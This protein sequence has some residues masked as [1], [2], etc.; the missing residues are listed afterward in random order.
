MSV[1]S[2]L[3]EGLR[4][5]TWLRHDCG[6]VEDVLVLQGKNRPEVSSG[7]ALN[8]EGLLFRAGCL[9][10]VLS[11]TSLTVLSVLAVMGDMIVPEAGLG[12][13]ESW[14]FFI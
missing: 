10:R 2:L 11:S 4:E 13:I 3:K 7:F 14:A 6:F 12:L 9:S 8:A 5:M 1:V